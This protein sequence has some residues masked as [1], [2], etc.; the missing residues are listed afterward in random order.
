MK[1]YKRTPIIF[2]KDFYTLQAIMLSKK[3]ARLKDNF[4]KELKDKGCPMPEKGFSSAKEYHAWRDEYKNKL[5]AYYSMME[6]ILKEFGVAPDGEYR[7]GLSFYFLFKE[8]KPPIK[9]QYKIGSYIAEDKQSLEVS[10]TIYPWTRKESLQ[11][12]WEWIEPAQKRLQGYIT[13]NREWEMFERNFKLYELFLQVEKDLE[14]GI[15]VNEKEESKSPY[16]NIVH[17]PEFEKIKVDYATHNLE[18]YVVD[19]VSDYKKKLQHI[20]IL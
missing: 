17:Y 5:P 4:Y 9:P 20:Q 16:V 14:K 8:N 18:D 7:N 15:K 12:I 6:D 2:D 13:R 3:F 10:L 11:D 1:K 19:I